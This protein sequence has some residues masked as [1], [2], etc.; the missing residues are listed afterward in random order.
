MDFIFTDLAAA[1]LEV[2]PAEQQ[3]VAAAASQIIRGG[4]AW[5][6]TELGN[7]TAVCLAAGAAGL[8]GWPLRPY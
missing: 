3:P 1:Q 6:N 2:Q 7:L 5:L 8:A 4:L